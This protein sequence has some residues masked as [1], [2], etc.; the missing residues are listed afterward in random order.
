MGESA[1]DVAQE[2]FVDMDRYLESHPMPDD[3]PAM[4]AEMTWKQSWDHLRRRVREHRRRSKVAAE[5]VPP[6]QPNPEEAVRLRELAEAIFEELSPEDEMTMRRFGHISAEDLKSA[7][8]EMGISVETLARRVS[9]ARRRFVEV[10]KRLR[11]I[12]DRDGGDD[13]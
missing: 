8:A 11:G 10:A 13:R 6:S 12:D 4:L 7:S 9:R 3:V 1:D 2:V 5:A